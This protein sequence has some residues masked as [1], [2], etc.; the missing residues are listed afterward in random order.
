MTPEQSPPEDL[1]TLLTT[2]AAPDAKARACR[3]LAVTG[4]PAA[5]PAL[6]GLLAHERL[7]DYARTALE[8]IP[9]P[10]AGDAL[11]RALPS[12]RGRLLAGAVDSLGVR[13]E[14]A[15][16]ADLL[17]LLRDPARGEESGALGALAKIATPEALAGIRAALTDGPAALRLPAATAAVAAAEHL[18]RGNRRPEAG[19]LLEPLRIAA[20][21]AHL[22][23]AAARLLEAA[24]RSRLFDGR[25]LTGWEGDPAWFRTGDGAIIA[26]RLDQPIPRNEF[27]CSTREFG[28]FEL[29][30]KVRLVAGQG[31]GGIQF[32]SQR[33]PD[34]REMAGYQADLAAGYWGGLYDES[35]RA[36]FLGQRAAAAEIDRLV[37]PG[38]W[39]DYVIRCEGPRV[40]LWLNGSLTTD[41]TES[42]PAIPRTGRLGLQIHASPP[43]EAWYRDLEL[44][45]LPPGP[46]H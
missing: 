46:T 23:E 38:G 5:V 15:A 30:L 17:A 25:T 8:A 9:G 6:A 14:A 29:R 43:A 39:N 11:R 44:A 21:T 36:R 4:G 7:A 10:A 16:V 13:R 37:K 35:R 40:R 45:E 19:A 22:R 28:D 2:D 1:I 41:F 26:G 27:L 20:P 32:R 33:V 34:S 24:A 42:D 31:N 3:Q 18:V 12:L